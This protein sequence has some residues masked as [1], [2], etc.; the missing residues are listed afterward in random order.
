MYT[1]A[2]C[3]HSL[4]SY[5]LVTLAEADT[6]YG[7]QSVSI[8]RDAEQREESDEAAERREESD[9]QSGNEYEAGTYN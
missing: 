1:C 5:F 2:W 9:I 8:E 6:G 7:E 4:T 3:L